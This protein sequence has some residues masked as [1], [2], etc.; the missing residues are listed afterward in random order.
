[1]NARKPKG[2]SYSKRF[3]ALFLLLF[4]L[5]FLGFGTVYYISP[6]GSDSNTGLGI[7]DELA[8]LTITKA[9]ETLTAGDTVEIL[10]GTYSTNDGNAVINPDNAGTSGNPITYTNYSTD[11]VY[12]RG[13]RYGALIN[14][15]YITIDGLHIEEAS[16]AAAVMECGVSL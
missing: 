12:I 15:D 11:T 8:W 6:T 9:N 13:Q 7:T 2:F 3:L 5:T 10:A 16:Q 4:S 14:V 1:M